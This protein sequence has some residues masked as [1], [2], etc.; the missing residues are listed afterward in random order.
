MRGEAACAHRR[1]PAPALRVA[2]RGVLPPFSRTMR[3]EW[4]DRPPSRLLEAAT[5]ASSRSAAARRARR[6]Y[7]AKTIGAHRFAGVSWNIYPTRRFGIRRGFL[8]EITS[9]RRAAGECCSPLAIRPVFRRGWTARAAAPMVKTVASARYFCTAAPSLF[10][11]ARVGATV[12]HR[13]SPPERRHVSTCQDEE[14]GQSAFLC[15]QAI[16]RSSFHARR[17]AAQAYR[18]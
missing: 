9:A 10:V 12:D 7:P 3:R 4:I 14:F 16:R 8:F 2:G 18:G 5:E 11:E 15:G 13:L 6:R 1:G 17:K